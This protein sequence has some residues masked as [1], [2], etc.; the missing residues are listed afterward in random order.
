MGAVLTVIIAL[1]MDYLYSDALQGT[2]R[3]A[4]VND[5]HSLFNVSLS[6]EGTVAYILFGLLLFVLS[7]VGAAIGAVFIFIVGR[8]LAF[9]GS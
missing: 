7:T 5:V 6:P 3:D 1:L 9:L 4:I 2:W 8:F